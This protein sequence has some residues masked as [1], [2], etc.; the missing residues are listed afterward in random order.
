MTRN[1]DSFMNRFFFALALLMLTSTAFAGGSIDR[2]EVM[3][4]VKQQPAVARYLERSLDLRATGFATRLGP[5]WKSLSAAR[6]GPY[7]ID[8]KAKGKSTLYN[9]A[10]VVCVETT[11]VDQAGKKTNDPAAAVKLSE[12]LLYVGV[13]EKSAPARDERAIC[14]PPPQ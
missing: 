13:V 1:D 4:I 12:K 14:P 8:A 11:F 5:H 9:L 6:V 2:A 3:A 7:S 10:V